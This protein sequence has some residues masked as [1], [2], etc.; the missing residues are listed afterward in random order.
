MPVARFFYAR[1]FPGHQPPPEATPFRNTQHPPGLVLKD[2]VPAL[3]EQNMMQHPD[4]R[5]LSSY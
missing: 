1:E 2:S 4:I 3:V 5:H